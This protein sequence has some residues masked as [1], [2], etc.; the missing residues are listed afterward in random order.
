MSLTKD[1]TMDEVSQNDMEKITESLGGD[2]LETDVVIN[3][4]MCATNFDFVNKMEF[5]GWN[6]FWVDYTCQYCGFDMSFRWEWKSEHGSASIEGIDVRK[7]I[8]SLIKESESHW[9]FRNLKKIALI[10][11][12]RKKEYDIDKV[13]SLPPHKNG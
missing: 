11:D 1:D 6:G 4:P 12:L 10:E 8:F 2:P 5:T 7:D 3:C 9:H 13:L